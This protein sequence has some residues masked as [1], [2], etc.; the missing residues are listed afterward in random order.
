MFVGE[1]LERLELR[2]RALIAQSEVQRAMLQLECIRLRAYLDDIDS[3]TEILKK[4]RPFWLVAVPA[5]G[6]LLGSRW[7][8]LTTWVPTGIIAWKTIRKV[9]SMWSHSKSQSAEGAA[10]SPATTDQT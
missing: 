3:G 9:W 4:T 2:R 6:I 1:E 5:L 8:R 10:A 7:R